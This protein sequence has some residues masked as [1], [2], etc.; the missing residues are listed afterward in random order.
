VNLSDLAE[1]VRWAR[2]RGFVEHP[3]EA[4]ELIDTRFLDLIAARN[5][6]SIASGDGGD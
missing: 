6:E 4:D 1:Y 3:I 5:R 2:E